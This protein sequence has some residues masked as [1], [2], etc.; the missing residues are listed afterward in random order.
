MWVWSWRKGRFHGLSARLKNVS[1]FPALG[2][3]SNIFVRATSLTAEILRFENYV[4]GPGR[5]KVETVRYPPVSCQIM[6]TAYWCAGA[7]EVL[8]CG[9]YVYHYYLRPLRLPL[10]T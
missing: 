1:E 8:C 6:A 10:S 9:Y 4:P 2:C 3:G 7:V 5:R